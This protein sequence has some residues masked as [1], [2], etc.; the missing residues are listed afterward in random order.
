MEI[1]LGTFFLPSFH[2][3]FLSFF[4]SFFPSCFF[5]FHLKGKYVKKSNQKIVESKN[6][7]LPWLE[8]QTVQYFEKN[9]YS[10]LLRDFSDGFE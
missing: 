8:E 6:L 7:A 2:S 10:K 4:L 9:F 3:F 1:L 5:L